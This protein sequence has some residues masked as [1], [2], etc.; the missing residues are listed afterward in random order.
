MREEFHDR[1][2]NPCHG[3]PD[4]YPACS[5]HCTKPAFLR[6]QE[7]QKKIREARAAYRQRAWRRE[8]PYQ[9]RNPLK[10]SKRDR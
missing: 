7:D 2:N 1:S 9:P 8:E 10:R 4:R 5:G 3:C 6:W